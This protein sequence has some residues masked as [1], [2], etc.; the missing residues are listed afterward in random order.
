[1]QPYKT[2]HLEW[3]VTCCG[4]WPAIKQAR[5]KIPFGICFGSIYKYAFLKKKYPRL[6]I[7]DLNLDKHVFVVLLTETINKHFCGFVHCA[8]K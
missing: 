7:Q 3:L 1:M 8:T 6:V 4:V 5:C 2:S